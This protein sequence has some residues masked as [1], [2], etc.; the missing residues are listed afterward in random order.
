M[1]FLWQETFV[2]VWQMTVT[3]DGPKNYACKGNCRVE[4]FMRYKIRKIFVSAYILT[5]WISYL[6]NIRRSRLNRLCNHLV[7]YPLIVIDVRKILL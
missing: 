7:Y 4:I 2:V 6:V 3:H 1:K 5:Y